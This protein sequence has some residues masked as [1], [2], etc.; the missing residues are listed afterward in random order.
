[1]MMFLGAI[2]F[3]LIFVLMTPQ[4]QAF[5]HVSAESATTFIHEW[6]PF[7]YILIGFLLIGPLAAM[8]VMH[9]WPRHEVPENPMVKYRRESPSV[10]DD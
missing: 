9:T 7:S 5:F 6:A 3:V 2:L 1:M 8:Y 4:V 10:N